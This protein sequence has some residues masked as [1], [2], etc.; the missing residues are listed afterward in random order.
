MRHAESNP[1]CEEC[2]FQTIAVVS[3]VVNAMV[4]GGHWGQW[5]IEVGMP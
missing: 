3:A 5:M 1:R 4:I 2:F